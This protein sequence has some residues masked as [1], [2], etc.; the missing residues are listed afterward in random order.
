LSWRGEPARG[1]GAEP[2]PPTRHAEGDIQYGRLETAAPG[3][4]SGARGSA[5][6]R[7]QEQKGLAPSLMRL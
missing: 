3:G 6:C 7:L 5:A 1:A 2:Q 4:A